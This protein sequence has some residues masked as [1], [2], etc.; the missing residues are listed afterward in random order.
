MSGPTDL[1][2]YPVPSEDY[3]PFKFNVE[4]LD[5]FVNLKKEKIENRVGRPSLTFYG[6]EQ[7]QTR[8]IDFFSQEF[9][10]FLASSG[11]SGG[12]RP[13]EAGID[14]SSHTQGFVRCEPD[15]SACLFYTPRGDT[16]LPY[17]TTGDWASESGLFVARGDDSLRQELGSA[18][19]GPEL[20]AFERSMLAQ[21]IGALSFFLSGTPYSLFEYASRASGTQNP[22]IKTWDWTDA[23]QAA[24]DSVPDGGTLFVPPVDFHINGK[25]SLEDKNI[26]IVMLGTFVVSRDQGAYIEIKRNASYVIG[27]ASLQHLPSK[28]DTFLY[29]QNSPTPEPQ[30]FFFSLTS[31]E[32]EITRI[33][34][35]AYTPYTKNEANEIIGSSYRLRAPIN[36]SYTDAAALSVSMYLKGTPVKIYG[37]R[38][39]VSDQGAAPAAKSRLLVMKGASNIS[40]ENCDIDRT[41]SNWPG[42]CVWMEECALLDWSKSYIR[43]FNSDSG[44]AYAW[45][46]EICAFIT[47]RE[48]G[49]VDGSGTKQERGW[50]ARH[51]SHILID[52]CRFSGVDDHYGHYYTVQ[53]MSMSR[54]VGISG[55]SLTVR[56]IVHRSEEWPLVTLRADSPYADGDLIIENCSTNFCLLWSTRDTDARKTKRK[57]WDRIKIENNYIEGRAARGAITVKH[58]LPTDEFETTSSL[59]AYDNQWLRISPGSECFF[60]HGSTPEDDGGTRRLWVGNVFFDENIFTNFHPTAYSSVVDGLK[61]DR[62]VSNS[63]QSILYTSLSAWNSQFTDDNIG[64][65]GGALFSFSDLAGNRMFNG[66]VINGLFNGFTGGAGRTFFSNCFINEDI[67]NDSGFTSSVAGMIGNIPTV[68]LPNSPGDVWNYKR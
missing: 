44:D 31:T 10:S 49:F 68:E 36:L 24:F 38:M 3:E 19:K 61:T 13:Y 53:N 46:G 32:P 2:K 1:T 12:D 60:F 63:N 35:P 9:Q 18:S 47:M 56:N 30:N 51:G 26:N 20:I 37:L 14:L 41:D 16:P 62:L 40:F 48:C 34:D 21:S 11:Y 45:L 55:G 7:R 43:G 27:G 8:M 4:T 29:V 15:G 64:L 22:D 52:N 5:K 50:A 6:M 65:D 28:G 17:T 33:G 59:K 42:I 57:T 39:R 25:V 67:F 23:L 66:C 58:N 54:G